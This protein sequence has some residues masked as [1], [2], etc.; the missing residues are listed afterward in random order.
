MIFKLRVFFLS[1]A[2]FPQWICYSFSQDI[3]TIS[4]KQTDVEATVANCDWQWESTQVGPLL[5]GFWPRGKYGIKLESLTRGMR[6]K[7][8]VT[9]EGQSIYSWKGNYKSVFRIVEN[10]LY[11]ADW[12]PIGTGGEIVAVDLLSAKELWR[13]KLKALGPISHTGYANSVRIDLKKD[14]I[15]IW[16]KESMGNYVEVKSLESGET[17]AHRVFPVP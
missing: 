5:E 9:D 2:F 1:L 10:R 4:T 8:S 11:F 12:S 17:I 7:I 15:W 3:N 13:K 6:V 16:G 14:G